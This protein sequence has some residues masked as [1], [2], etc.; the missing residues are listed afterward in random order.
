MQIPLFRHGFGKQWLFRWHPA[1]TFF[2]ITRL[3]F[4]RS[5][6]FSTPSISCAC[7]CNRTLCMHP[8]KPPPNTMTCL[9]ASTSFIDNND[10]EEEEEEGDTRGSD[11]SSSSILRDIS[12]RVIFNTISNQLPSE[13]LLCDVNSQLVVITDAVLATYWWRH[14]E[15]TSFPDRNDKWIPILSCFWKCL[16][17]LVIES[18]PL[19]PFLLLLLTLRTVPVSVKVR[20]EN[21][22][23]NWS[24][25]AYVRNKIIWNVQEKQ[26]DYY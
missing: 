12:R 21:R 4:K 1:R 3:L 26:S 23:K 24:F 2:F 8:T 11:I 15:Q 22:K 13:T 10:C 5:L 16:K 17:S 19:S 25:P 14:N 18:S 9:N 7:A 6:L 20:M